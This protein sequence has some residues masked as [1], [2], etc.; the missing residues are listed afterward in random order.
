M[1][2]IASIFP[3]GGYTLAS[4]VPGFLRD[5]LIAH[6]LGTGFAADAFFVSQ[7]FPNLF[8]SL[9]AE[10]AFNASFVPRFARR[11]EGEGH[12]AARQFSEQAMAAMTSVLLLFTLIA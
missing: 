5:I 8:R 1:N 3:V 9:F 10:G 11:L 4:R 2:L 12:G 7:R 6:A